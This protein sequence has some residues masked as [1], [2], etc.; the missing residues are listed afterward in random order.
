[1][2]YW[3]QKDSKYADCS[4]RAVANACRFYGLECPDPETAAWEEVVDFTGCRHGAA[5]KDVDRIAEYFG[6]RATRIAASKVIGQ[7]PALLTV[8]NPDVGTSLHC[9]L[10]VGWQD[11]VA[12]VLNY[13]VKE[14]PIVPVEP[15]PHF[16]LPVEA[17]ELWMGTQQGQSFYG[18]VCVSRSAIQ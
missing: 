9:V 1:M 8:W 15:N 12:T 2:K 10:V 11:N 7:L 16:V 18:H 6:L 5:T 13:R 4:P 17:H 14:G 3:G